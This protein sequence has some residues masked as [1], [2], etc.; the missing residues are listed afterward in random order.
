MTQ[1]LD[2]QPVGL[3]QQRQQSMVSVVTCL[4]ACSDDLMQA[5]GQRVRIES[6]ESANT[7][8]SFNAGSPASLRAEIAG[9]L[10]V[11]ESK[12]MNVVEVFDRVRVPHQKQ[13]FVWTRMVGRRRSKRLQNGTIFCLPDEQY[14]DEDDDDLDHRLYFCLNKIVRV[15]VA[16]AS[17]LGVRWRIL[18]IVDPLEKRSM[19]RAQAV[20]L[21]GKSVSVCLPQLRFVAT[22][23]PAVA[24][25]TRLMLPSRLEMAQHC[26]TLPDKGVD[27]KKWC[28]KSIFERF[29]LPVIHLQDME[30]GEYF[31]CLLISSMYFSFSF[32]FL[33]LLCF[34]FFLLVRYYFPCRHD[35]VRSSQ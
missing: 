11:D 28:E 16:L 9:F 23:K 12:V 7:M 30:R 24:L 10:G 19:N 22:S 1:R 18:L 29:F 21:D 27:I 34:V 6:L 25:S 32:F 17:G 2:K 5:H 26:L 14:G 4:S 20:T 8:L 15:E 31:V 33:F 13:A 35:L 3:E